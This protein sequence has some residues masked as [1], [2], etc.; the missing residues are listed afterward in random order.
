[1]KAVARMEW[2]G[3]PLDVETL[4]RFREGWMSIQDRLI[5]EID[6]R[7]GV[8][9][10][11]TFKADRFADWLRRSGIAWPKHESGALMLDDDT[12]REFARSST[13]VS[14]IR[15][16]RYSLAQLRLEDLAV[17]S[18]GRNRVLLS[19]FGAS[20]SRNTPSNSRFVFGPSTWL[21]GLI[22]PEPGMAVAYVDW[23]QQE[24]GI[25]AALSGDPAMMEAYESGDPYLA[26]GKR[27]GRIP[28][29]GTRETHAVERELFKTCILGVQYG[30]GAG[31]LA[32]RIG[33]PVVYARDLL[34]LHR[35]TYPRFWQWSDGAE[36]CAMLCGQLHSVF[37]WTI[38]ALA[39]AN[40][41]SLRNFPCQANGAE[42]MRLG[43]SLVLD[44]GVSVLAPVHDAL[45]IEGLEWEIEDVVAQAQEAMADASAIILGG[46]RLRSNAGIV[47][48]PDRYMDR[49]G[50]DFW[51][52]VMSLLDPECEAGYTA[53]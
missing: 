23:S 13:D 40:P 21:R 34:R 6:S 18:D 44:R 53:A 1:M 19:P 11:H 46:F 38:C 43:C 31:S 10:G 50:K 9:D 7:F 22:K 35:E 3:V 2:A 33:K 45:L 12:F 8:F 27:A 25:A 26:F 42:M 30:M 39:D 29:H 24:F 48:W 37:G 5:E 15:E 49:R 17:G 47:R 4:S 41:R 52:Q 16:L 36:M 14:L 51:N 20:T 28:L 32:R